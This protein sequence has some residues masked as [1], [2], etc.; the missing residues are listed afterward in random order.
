MDVTAGNGMIYVLVQQGWA[1]A[2]VRQM[3]VETFDPRT[4]AATVMAPVVMGI[5]GSAIAHTDFTY[6]E[7]SLWLSAEDQG[8][9]GPT[10]T[11]V[12]ISP[13]TGQ[14]LGSV[15][16]VPAIGGLFPSVVA[17]TSGTWFAGGPGGS[18]DLVELPT[19]SSVTRT[20]YAGPND[21]AVIWLSAVRGRCGLKSP[22]TARGRNP[23][24]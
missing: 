12:R 24:F 1:E 5:V 19:G 22:T 17:D 3:H 10:P 2:N 15:T 8:V 9:G 14:S 23:R 21:S 6:G 4:G 20:T 7:G 11:V 18:P 13:L 16:S